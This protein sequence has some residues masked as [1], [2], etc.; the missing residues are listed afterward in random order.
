MKSF[1]RHNHTV[2]VAIVAIV[3]ASVAVVLAAMP[4]ILQSIGASFTGSEV[5]CADAPYNNQCICPPGTDRVYV[6]TGLGW[7]TAKL[8]AGH[9]RTC[10]TRSL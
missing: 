3:L 6:A 10:R 4:G 8:T 5:Y 7:G 9:R 1:K 2:A